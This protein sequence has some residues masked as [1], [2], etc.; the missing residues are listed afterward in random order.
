MYESADRGVT[1]QQ[2]AEIDGAFWSTLFVHNGK[3]YLMGATK[4]YGDTMIRRSDDGGRTWT[5]PSSA[6]TGLLST[7]GGYHCAPQPVL[8]HKGRIWRAMEDN[9]GGQGWG[10]HFRAFMMSAPED[11][12][13]L[14]AKNWTIS[15]ALSR[16]SKWLGGKFGGWL[17]GNAVAAPDGGIVNI[18]R[19]EVPAGDGKAAVV[20]VSEDGTE[21]SFDPATG[22]I[23]MPGGSTK[24]AIRF[25]PVSNYYWALANY[26]PKRHVSRGRSPGGIRNTLALIRSKDLRQWQL[27]TIVAYHPDVQHHG[28]QYPDWQF[29][30]EDLVVVSRTAYD[31]EFGGAHSFHDAN[32]LTFHRVCDFRN[33]QETQLPPLPPPVKTEV[34]CRDFS[35][36]TINTRIATLGEDEVAYGN[37]KYVWKNVPDRFAG[38]Q[39]TRTD[40]GVCATIDVTA[41][42]ATTLFMAAA[43][44]QEQTDTTGWTLVPDAT[45]N[46]T[47]GGKTRMQV[48]SRQ[49]DAGQTVSVPQG[50]WSG[51]LLLIPPEDRPLTQTTVTGQEQEQRPNVLFIAVDDLRVEVGC[52]GD[53]IVKDAEYRSAG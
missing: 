26:I 39:Y 10:K 4:R 31:D 45:F 47:D 28:F 35:V 17:E 41:Q 24:F 44:K 51:G 48:Y 5:T 36:V 1:W 29:D 7:D 40:G 30:G 23:D 37:R 12:D 27:R 32:Y 52:Y 50:G 25:D 16:D 42:C 34:R 22:F 20:E 19:V 43:P 2:I 9:R 13:L 8:M 38:W 3:L 11:A 53:T 6:Q 21:A 18:L 14:D 46:Y 33:A 15:S 49:V